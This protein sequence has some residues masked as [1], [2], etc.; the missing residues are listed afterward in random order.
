MKIS[1]SLIK[2]FELT[3]KL[4]RSL[5]T[6]ADT[7]YDNTMHMLK[8][9]DR[10]KLCAICGCIGEEFSIAIIYK[11]EPFEIQSKLNFK[12]SNRK[13]ED[14]KGKSDSK[15]E[16]KYKEIIKRLNAYEKQV[17]VLKTAKN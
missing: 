5:N 15:D 14:K 4:T 6:I 2:R 3:N 12:S 16:K 13:E 1:N 8:Y 9:L 17:A 11:N 10:M 7:K